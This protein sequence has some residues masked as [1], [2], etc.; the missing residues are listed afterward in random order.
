MA[1]ALEL[2]CRYDRKIVVEAATPNAREIEVSVLGNDDP[3]ASVPGE[4][5]PAKEFYSYAAKY[6]DDSSDL[7]IPA[8]LSDAQFDTIKSFAAQGI[9]ELRSLWGRV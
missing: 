7:L 1:T 8:P 6:I 9:S 4:I 5:V 2:A 3:I